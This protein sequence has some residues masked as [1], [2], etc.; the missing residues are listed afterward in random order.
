MVGEWGISL[1]LLSAVDVPMRWLN[2]ALLHF[3]GDSILF[4]GIRGMTIM[5][6]FFRSLFYF[7]GNDV[8]FLS[9]I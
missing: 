3:T 8:N 2:V 9:N 6:S 4:A 7:N 1:G 5:E